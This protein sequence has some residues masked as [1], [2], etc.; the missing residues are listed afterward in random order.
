M[1]GIDPINGEDRF[2]FGQMYLVDGFPLIPVILALFAFPR[3]LEMVR[4]VFASRKKTVTISNFDISGAAISF[5]ELKRIGRTLIRSSIL[6]TFIG[7]IPGAGAN[8]A[9]WVGYSEA[10]RKSKHQ[11]KFGKG[12]YEGVAAA[13]AANNSTEGGSL[14]PMLTLSIPGSSAAAVMF[15]A[16]MIHGMVPGPML[17]T[18]YAATTY[19]YIWAIICN[20]FILLAIGYYGSRLFANFARVPLIIL[21]PTMLLITMLGAFAERQLVFDVGVTVV[22]GTIFYLLSLA[23]YPMPAILLGVILGPIAEKGFRRAMLISNNDWTIFFTRPISLIILLL[24]IFSLYAGIRILRKR[25][26]E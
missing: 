21:A 15:G 7:M 18:K 22:L 12:N 11:E 24:S 23:R 2:T 13:E 3:S 17:F 9:C 8:I 14:I 20:S 6:G 19:T 1:V 10:R 16:L 26:N 4:D 5:K 25:K